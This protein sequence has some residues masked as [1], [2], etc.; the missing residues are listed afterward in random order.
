MNK[1]MTCKESRIAVRN[2]WW[3][4]NVLGR[5]VILFFLLCP[6]TV[7]GATRIGT[8]YCE[9]DLSGGLNIWGGESVRYV[10]GHTGLACRSSHNSDDGSSM[11]FQV[12][13]Q[14][15]AT[16]ELYV[17]YWLKYESGYYG[18]CATPRIWN[19]KWFWSA[20]TG[21]GWP[22]L[23]IIWQGYSGTTLSGIAQLSEGGASWNGSSAPQYFNTSYTMGDWMHVEIYIKQSSSNGTASD[24]TI[25][26][27]M[28]G[29][30]VINNTNVITGVWVGMPTPR[31]PG[32]KG[33]CACPSGSG[34]WQIDD[35]E[36][37]DGMPT[38]QTG[39]RPSMV[40]GLRVMQTQ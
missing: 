18:Y 20:S 36:V 10:A 27:T 7:L 30:N 2:N 3:R 15:P 23:E 28:N 8:L 14:F 13:N 22:H 39:D 6:L 17:S 33:S 37:W 19:T 1:T 21:T 25:R 34:W 24:G 5:F 31:G 16:G 40:T 26:L 32:I 38:G 11:D 35:Y 4:H 12:Y 29:T 9:G